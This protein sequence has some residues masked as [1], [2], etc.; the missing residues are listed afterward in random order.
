MK[1]IQ[2]IFR[3][4]ILFIIT[5]LTLYGAVTMTI[6]EYTENRVS[7]TFSGTFD[8]DVVSYLALKN[9]W[10][11]NIGTQTDWFY[12]G[13]TQDLIETNTVAINGTPIGVPTIQDGLNNHNDSIHWNIS[14][15]TANTGSTIS[16]TLVLNYLY[17]ASQGNQFDPNDASTLQ[18]VS[19]WDST[20]N[21]WATLQANATLGQTSARTD[22]GNGFWLEENNVTVTCADAN[23]GDSST[24]NAPNGSPYVKIDEITDVAGSYNANGTD[25][26]ATNACTTGVTSFYLGFYNQ[27]TFND[28]VSH[29][30]TSSVTT[31]MYM[32]YN[33]TDFNQS[34]GSWDTSSVTNMIGMFGYAYAF[35][36]DIGDWNTSSVESMHT[37]FKRATKFNQD[38]SSWDTSSV[39]SMES[40]FDEAFVF[41]QDIGSWDTSSV[42]SMYRMFYTAKVFNQNIG[43]WDTSSVTDMSGMFAVARAF[44]QDISDWNTSSVTSM[45]EMFYFADVFDQCLKPWDVHLIGSE[46]TNFDTSSVFD[47]DA[48]KLPVWGTTGSICNVIPTV[49]VADKSYTENDPASAIDS[50]ATASDSDGDSNWDTNA[51]LVV[52]ITANNETSDEISID[53]SGNFSISSGT[54]S[55]SGTDIGTISESSG[56]ANDGIVTNDDNLTINFN[57]SATN[58]IVQNL[59]QSILYRSTSDD[60]TA[61]NTTRTIT[62][63]LTDKN[64]ASASDTSTITITAQNDAPTFTINNTNYP[65]AIGGSGDDTTY[66][67]AIDSEDNLIAAGSIK[68]N[69]DFDT[70]DGV[71]LAVVDTSRNYPDAFVAKYD[72][73][74]NLKWKHTFGDDWFDR[75]YDVT[76]DSQD[77]VYVSGQFAQWS[78]DGETITSTGYDGFIWKLDKDGNS[79][80]FKNFRAQ[81]SSAEAVV[82]GLAVDTSG[83]I[84]GVGSFIDEVDFD[85]SAGATALTPYVDSGESDT[86]IVKLDSNGDLLWVKQ[87][88]GDDPDQA[89]SVKIDTSGNVYV[90]GIFQADA[91][92]IDLD[93]DGSTD[94]NPTS[95]GNSDGSYS[96]ED[97]DL[98]FV[99]KYDTSGNHQWTKMFYGDNGDGDSEVTDIAL[100]TSGNVYVA[101]WFEDNVD[102]NPDPNTNNVEAM[103]ND[104]HGFLVKLD[105][106]GVYQWHKRFGE[107]ADDDDPSDNVGI[108]KM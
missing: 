49:T 105:S 29:W 53:T 82:K 85:P 62:F 26:N 6:T 65:M 40:M 68:N 95:T 35:D 47:G 71:S 70:G 60:P 72:K 51:T 11:N 14:G 36:Q 55:Y 13:N 99:A 108:D 20:P 15:G 5:Q 80:W 52:Q 18:L 101:G 3:V 21:D 34:I 27:P 64:E 59:V 79:I 10:S 102:F 17:S 37:M 46:P 50:S 96:N 24:T 48:D 32:F 81:N 23:V 30:D 9:D 76:V 107:D 4:I 54:L 12:A 69:V 106:D 43:N 94:I 74:G 44:N 58:T 63:T 19:G 7:I 16:G 78:L 84:Y 61:N 28:D 103:D 31:M 8:S 90:G 33:A 91:G 93:G 89:N 92:G 39:T 45:D 67:I 87:S 42:T 83:N 100:D 41:N 98:A 97:E 38:I 86:F 56:T 104:D 22:L 57:S 2:A 75:A 88:G 73:N 77:N 25:V 66:D 1:L